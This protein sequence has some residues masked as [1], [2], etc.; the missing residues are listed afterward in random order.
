MASTTCLGLSSK[1]QSLPSPDCG[2]L[3]LQQPLRRLLGLSLL[4]LSLLGLGLLGLPLLPTAPVPRQ[5]ALHCA[6]L[7]VLRW[8]SR[9]LQRIF[10]R[11]VF[12]RGRAGALPKRLSFTVSHSELPRGGRT[13]RTDLLNALLQARS[14]GGWLSGASRNRLFACEQGSAVP[15]ASVAKTKQ[16]S[17]SKERVISDVLVWGR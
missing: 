11:S 9:E 7:Q 2:G 13:G 4:R 3:A 17:R 16:G 1:A 15:R 5:L 8:R 10:Q 6:P 12:Q 14:L